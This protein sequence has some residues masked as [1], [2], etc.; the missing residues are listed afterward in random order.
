MAIEDSMRLE[1]FN[2]LF[3][4][5]RLSSLSTGIPP[6]G[7][8]GTWPE[9]RGNP[10]HNQLKMQRKKLVLR[11]RR[12]IS[13]GDEETVCNRRPPP[14]AFFPRIKNRVMG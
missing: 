11:D 10:R 6:A 7:G 12:G 13:A 1:T 8:D 2:P 9:N 3:G 14:S 4:L 5:P